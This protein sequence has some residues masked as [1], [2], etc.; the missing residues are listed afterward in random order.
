MSSAE[1][2]K[3]WQARVSEFEASGMSAAAW[4][5]A[6]GIGV[7]KLLYW[8]KKFQS[9]APQPTGCPQWLPIEF[10]S[11]SSSEDCLKVRVGQAVVEVRTGFDPGLLTEVVRSLSKLC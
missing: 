1:L 4:A 10:G 5:A 6:T 8:S 9:S 11:S 3:E 2:Q 7:H